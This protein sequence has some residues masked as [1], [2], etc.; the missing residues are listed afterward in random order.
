M[1]MKKSFVIAVIFVCCGINAVCGKKKKKEKLQSEYYNPKSGIKELSATHFPSKGAKYIWLVQFYKQNCR[2]CYAMKSAFSRA[3]SHIK[4][5][6]NGKSRVK[7]GAFDCSSLPHTTA[8]KKICADHGAIDGLQFPRLVLIKSGISHKF[9]EG[10]K[11]TTKSLLRFVYKFANI[12][13]IPSSSTPGKSTRS[14]CGAR[15][16]IYH[17]SSG[18]TNLCDAFFPKKNKHKYNWIVK[19]YSGYDG[20]SRW[21]KERYYKRL[22]TED[23]FLKHKTTLKLGAI[24]C[25]SNKRNRKLCKQ[26]NVQKFPTLIAFKSHANPIIFNENIINWETLRNFVA[27]VAT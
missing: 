17:R 19:F 1:A 13:F 22:A 27:S 2:K 21:F 16:G 10:E 3:A 11:I 18:V 12:P 5:D 26:Y 15:D 8:N 4:K 14:K 7:L 23:I 25:V 24:N 9:E 6:S 20:N